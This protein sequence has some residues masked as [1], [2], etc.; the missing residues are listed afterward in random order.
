[1]KK[2]QIM[3]I[4]KEAAVGYIDGDILFWSASKNYSLKNQAAGYLANVF[5]LQWQPGHLMTVVTWTFDG[6]ILDFVPSMAVAELL[7]VHGDIK[8][9][10]FKLPAAKCS[11]RTRPPPEPPPIYRSSSRHFHIEVLWSRILK[12]K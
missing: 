7:Q 8:R 10:G 1:M 2:P 12:G 3:P 5:K 11:P 9:V 6:S 4:K